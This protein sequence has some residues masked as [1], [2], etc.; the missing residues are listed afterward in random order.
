MMI[1]DSAPASLYHIDQFHFIMFQIVVS[2][3]V[4]DRKIGSLWLHVAYFLA[5][6]K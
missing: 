4:H 2:T 1:I 3:T 6:P 5:S